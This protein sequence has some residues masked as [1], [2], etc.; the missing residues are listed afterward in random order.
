MT[1]KRVGPAGS[2]DRNNAHEKG[3]ALLLE[4]A[5]CFSAEASRQSPLTGK[6][7]VVGKPELR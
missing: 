4:N 5:C 1:M 7:L 2:S 6:K 3:T